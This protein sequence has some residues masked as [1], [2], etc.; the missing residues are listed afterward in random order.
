MRFEAAMFEVLSADQR[1][2]VH[3]DAEAIETTHIKE[4]WLKNVRDQTTR[5][6][7][8][9]NSNAPLV[10]GRKIGLAFL[11]NELI[12]FKRSSQIPVEDP[13]GGKALLSMPKAILLAI[14]YSV[15]VSVPV[16]GYIGGIVIGGGALLSGKNILGRYTNNPYNRLY[17]LFLLVMSVAAWFPV[18]FIRGDMG[19][20]I[21][22]HIQMATWMVVITVLFQCIKLNVEKKYFD[23]ATVEL[24]SAWLN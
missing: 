17:A 2:V 16:F 4:A 14:I 19:R 10:A 7:A 20:L 22:I 12:A 6:V 11:N 23:L 24:N 3:G 21:D 5:K 15:L 18:Q 9:A 1:S 8:L 13:V